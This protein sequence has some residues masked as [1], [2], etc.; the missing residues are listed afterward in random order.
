MCTYVYFIQLNEQSTRFRSG[1]TQATSRLD[2]VGF[3]VYF[4]QLNDSRLDSGRVWRL[5][6]SAERTV[7]SIPVRF[8]VYFIQLNDSRLDLGRVWRLFRSAERTFSRLDLGRV[9]RL[10][11]FSW[12]TVD[13]NWVVFDVYSCSAERESTQF[14]SGFTSTSSSCERRRHWS[15]KTVDISKLVRIKYA[16]DLLL[17]F[18]I[19]LQSPT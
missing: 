9:W 19:M 12:T 17:P 6:H 4:I 8:D 16:I 18:R 2:L 1:L 15:G 3:D 14:G 5:L 13:S 7:D 11:L 10:L